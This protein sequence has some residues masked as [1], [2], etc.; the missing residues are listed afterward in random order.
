MG[1]VTR[2]SSAGWRRKR[3][4][5]NATAAAVPTAVAIAVAVTATLRLLRSAARIWGSCAARAYQSRVKPVQAAVSRP[6]L[7]EKA[8]ST[9]IGA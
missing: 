4:R 2:V 1:S 5:W 7:N 6:A 9:R 3:Q 8:T